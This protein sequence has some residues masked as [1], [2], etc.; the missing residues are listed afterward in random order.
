[1][2][3]L[4][5]CLWICV[6]LWAALS[7]RALARPRCVLPIAE[8]GVFAW[9]RTGANAGLALAT[10]PTP[11]GA[12]VWVGAP[13]DW[14]GGEEAGAAALLWWP[15]R[16]G[17]GAP[18]PRA[19]LRGDVE[20]E[21][22]GAAIQVLPDLDGDA[23]PEVAVG[24]PGSGVLRL[25]AGAAWLRSAPD[26][27]AG[28]ARR[29][30]LPVGWGAWLMW[31]GAQLWAGA[32]G[33]TGAVSISREALGIAL[34]GG[35][36]SQA[37][38][39]GRSALRPPADQL[40][41]GDW[42]GDGVPEIAFV[43]AETDAPGRAA[44]LSG[45]CLATRAGHRPHGGQQEGSRALRAAAPLQATGPGAAVGTAAAAMPGA[46]ALGAPLS[47]TGGAVLLLQSAPN[48]AEAGP[49]QRTAPWTRRRSK[50]PGER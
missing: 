49:P 26:D 13:G 16:L 45:R 14:A 24:A 47:G 30:A 20:G 44:V 46:L 4:R 6:L 37:P 1:M 31:D 3:S 25:V 36:P 29:V 50:N 42:D 43:Q 21:W 39:R 41:A 5:V 34:A 48:T 40:E 7:P 28:A 32:D 33:Q 23:L 18:R 15:T 38:Q 17:D 10:L 19:E 8:A 35:A 27:L 22:L 12:H 11:G 9:P 2:L